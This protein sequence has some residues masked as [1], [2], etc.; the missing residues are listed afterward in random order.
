[1]QQITGGLSPLVDHQSRSPLSR[2]ALRPEASV[3]STHNQWVDK[4][5]VHLPEVPSHSPIKTGTPTEREKAR[6]LVSS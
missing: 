4:E 3:N 1:M 2:P 5:A 6:P